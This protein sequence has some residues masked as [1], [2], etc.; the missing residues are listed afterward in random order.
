VVI[1]VK[2]LIIF[3]FAYFR[4]PQNL[5]LIPNYNLVLSV[6]TKVVVNKMQ[7]ENHQS[8]FGAIFEQM[9]SNVLVAFKLCHI[10][11]SIAENTLD[12]A[13]YMGALIE[14]RNV[15]ITFNKDNILDLYLIIHSLRNAKLIYRDIF[16]PFVFYILLSSEAEPD[17]SMLNAIRNEKSLEIS[18]LIPVLFYYQ[19]H[20]NHFHNSI[21]KNPKHE[22]A[23]IFNIRWKKISRAVAKL[24][25]KLKITQCLL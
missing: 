7:L 6:I 20:L 17:Y 16:D 5:K 18:E 25:Q 4:E 11:Q 10:F 2:N 24:P 12:R 8:T 15:L 13:F 19:K 3:L 1:T 9:K 22:F 21:P 23:W 14:Y